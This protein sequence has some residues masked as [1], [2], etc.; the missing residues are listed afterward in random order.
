MNT[1]TQTSGKQKNICESLKKTPVQ[2]I[3][4]QTLHS[5]TTLSFI[6]KILKSLFHF[7]SVFEAPLEQKKQTQLKKFI[8]F[9]LL[10]T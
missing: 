3:F 6:L 1:D 4:S 9:F 5:P 7:S 2:L 8:Y 10:S